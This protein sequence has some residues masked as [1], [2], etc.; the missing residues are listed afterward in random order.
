M[1]AGNK[2][3]FET[4]LAENEYPFFGFMKTFLRTNSSIYLVHV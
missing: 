2:K 1:N 4:E 3:L